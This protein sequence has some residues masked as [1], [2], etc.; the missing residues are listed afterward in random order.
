[1]KIR[2]ILTAAA[3]AAPFAMSAV[4]AFPG[5]RTMVNPD[6]STVELLQHGDRH[7]NYWTDADG[8]K[9]M[10]RDG[11]GRWV[12]ARRNG[13]LM[14]T[15]AA[16]LNLL[17]SEVLPLE[18][19]VMTMAMLDGGGRTTYPTIGDPHA[20]V[21]LIQFQDVKFTVPDI[22][23]A[24]DKMLNERGYSD[25][26]SV[27]SAVDYYSACSNGKF[28]PK[29]DVCEV[30]TLPENLSY[31][32]APGTY[33]MGYTYNDYYLS[34]GLRYA[35]EEVHD[36]QGVDFSKYDYDDDSKIDNV[37]F[38]YAGYGEAD[39]RHRDTEHELIW[40]HQ[41]DY[42]QCNVLYDDWQPLVLD[43][44]SFATYACGNE[45]PGDIP[46]DASYPYLNGIGTF[47]H[48][49]GHVLGLP[50]LYDTQ[51]T[52][53][54]TPGKYDLMD[55]GSYN[56]GYRNQMM[57]QPP[58]LSAYERWVLNWVDTEALPA[59]VEDD[60]GNLY[61]GK[62]IV[63][64][65]NSIG[66]INI[67]YARM[68]R[69]AGKSYWPEYYFFETRTPDGWDETLPQHGLYIW[70]VK[71]DRSKW[72]SNYVNTY[73][74]PCVELIGYNERLADWTWGHT[75]RQL[76]Y[77]YPGSSNAI[78]P[79]N[80]CPADWGFFL[81]DLNYNEENK[82]TTFGYNKYMQQTEVAPVLYTPWRSNVGRTLHLKW[83][84]VEGATSYC[85]TLYRYDSTG[86][87]KIIDTK[88]ETDV[89]NIT[90]IDITGISKAA[91]D[92]EIHAYVRPVI[93][94]PGKNKS[95]E[96]VF[97]PAELGITDP[98]DSAVDGIGAD[99]ADFYAI[100][101]AGR[102]EASEG[103]E[104]YNMSGMRVGM[105]NLPAGVYVVRNNGKSVKVYVK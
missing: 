68:K 91:W 6:G 24:I 39:G 42:T 102:I 18:K 25:Y 105:E 65:S 84:A 101:L 12:Q 64:P 34:K 15:S 3:L 56:G 53:T 55:S 7:F 82:E 5:L 37:F 92:M 31:Y 52:G 62:D 41:G 2:H 21:V 80:T 40:P 86:N 63:L 67:E 10:E 71:F 81:T 58:L 100:G 28:T 36:K 47:C 88:D 22:R 95:N 54:K 59:Y 30:V 4:P 76:S 50:D 98:N 79:A 9:I 72:T 27:G 87:R 16:D 8:A 14:T 57:T 46:T 74:D 48:E 33:G 99:D 93:G 19:P 49:Y 38:F 17:R 23:N 43:G 104:A 20:L 13:R 11:N 83:D 66:E 96:Q 51:A 29:F 69:P 70:H 97:I 85:L 75:D 1:M 78:I 90:E 26:N 32:G 60:E 44:K 73:S 89:G 35:L 61:E 94:V 103:S 45:L 77:V